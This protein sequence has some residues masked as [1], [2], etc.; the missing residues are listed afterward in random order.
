M[1][2][3]YKDKTK[4]SYGEENVIYCLGECEL[5]LLRKMWAMARDNVS[6]G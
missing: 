6:Y 5:L 2:Y 3:G 4:L 1:N